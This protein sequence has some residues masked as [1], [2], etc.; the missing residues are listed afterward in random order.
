MADDVAQLLNYVRQ[1]LAAF[2]QEVNTR[3]DRL[4]TQDAF[5]AERRRVDE[6]IAGIGRELNAEKLARK[7]EATEF[8]GEIAKIGVWVRWSLSLAIAVPGAVGA[9]LIIL[10]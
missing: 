3:L 9:I 5:E 2:R 7:E 6:R 4:V 10:K 1:D 8:R